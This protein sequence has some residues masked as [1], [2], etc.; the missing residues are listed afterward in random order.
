MGAPVVS[1][2]RSFRQHRSA[3]LPALRYAPADRTH[4]GRSGARDS[5]RGPGH[6]RPSPITSP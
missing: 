2:V 5:T 4:A 6:T 1:R 3:H